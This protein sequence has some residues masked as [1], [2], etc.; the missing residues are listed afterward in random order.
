MIEEVKMYVVDGR[1]FKTKAEA[2][3]AYRAEDFKATS[4]EYIQA[5][6]YEGRAAT[7]VANEIKKFLAWEASLSDA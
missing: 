7:R 6:G 5:M 4:D 3:A 2:I 1:K